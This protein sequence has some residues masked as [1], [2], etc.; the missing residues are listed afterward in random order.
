MDTAGAH[1]RGS[2][3]RM[4]VLNPG[5]KPIMLMSARIFSRAFIAVGK[6][7]HAKLLEQAGAV[8]HLHEI[9]EPGQTVTVDLTTG[10]RAGFL[11]LLH[12]RSLASYSVYRWPLWMLRSAAALE[13]LDKSR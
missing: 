4:A 2:Y 3:Y 6:N 13:A 8:T 10:D 12:W 9:V 1:V 11:L 7:E 5:P